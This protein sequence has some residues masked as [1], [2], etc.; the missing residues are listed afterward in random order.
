MY[1]YYT[2]KVTGHY[3]VTEK[4]LLNFIENYRELYNKVNAERLYVMENEKKPAFSK[5]FD[6]IKLKSKIIFNIKEELRYKIDD[7]I[8]SLNSSV[9]I[10]L[11]LMVQKKLKMLSIGAEK[12][13]KVKKAGRSLQIGKES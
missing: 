7:M 2:V 12:K 13:L 3:F 10:P 11:D 1:L 8:A 5:E 9:T 4:G 6:T